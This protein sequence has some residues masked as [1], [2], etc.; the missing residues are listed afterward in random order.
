MIYTC[1]FYVKHSEKND[2]HGYKLC[3]FVYSI[4]FLQ[5]VIWQ[6]FWDFMVNIAPALTWVSVPCKYRAL[7]KRKNVRII[8]EF[9]ETFMIY[10]MI[11]TKVNLKQAHMSKCN[12]NVIENVKRGKYYIIFKVVVDNT[13]TNFTQ[14]GAW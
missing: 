2:V 8:C 6:I 9:K 5:L 1:T 14:K 4:H 3:F 7:N 11:M 13:F 12:E 10:G